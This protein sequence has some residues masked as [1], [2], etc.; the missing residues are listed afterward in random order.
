[1]LIKY[2]KV[3]AEISVGPLHDKFIRPVIYFRARTIVA[4]VR[5]V[6]IAQLAHKQSCRYTMH[7]F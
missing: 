1:M 6:K 7:C 5:Y 3:G 2:Y 4:I